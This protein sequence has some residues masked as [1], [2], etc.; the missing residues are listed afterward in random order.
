MTFSITTKTF[1]NLNIWKKQVE[2]KL[3]NIEGWECLMIFLAEREE[4]Y[5]T[6]EFKIEKSNILPN[7]MTLYSYQILGMVLSTFGNRK[8]MKP[9]KRLDI[10]TRLVDV[11]LVWSSSKTFKLVIAPKQKKSKQLKVTGFLVIRIDKIKPNHKC[12]RLFSW[13]LF[14][15]ERFHSCLLNPAHLLVAFFSITHFMPTSSGVVQ[16]V[17]HLQMISQNVRWF[18]TPLFVFFGF[19]CHFSGK[20]VQWNLNNWTKTQVGLLADWL[21]GLRPLNSN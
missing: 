20:S 12:T 1:L 14:P 18:L 17:F 5:Y 16:K 10:K 11:L 15:F 21:A 13:R 9:L 2:R 7:M 6:W 3:E 4:C 8:D 19:W